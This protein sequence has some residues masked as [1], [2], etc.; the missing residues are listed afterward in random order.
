MLDRKRI[1]HVSGDRL[2]SWAVLSQMLANIERARVKGWRVSYPYFA[3]WWIESAGHVP[4][5]IGATF[6]EA[7]RWITEHP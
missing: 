1:K 6:E 3:A 2:A 4:L 5:C 7:R